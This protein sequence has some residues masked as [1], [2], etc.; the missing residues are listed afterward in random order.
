M[1]CSLRSRGQQHERRIAR[2]RLPPVAWRVE[3]RLSSGNLRRFALQFLLYL[4]FV[5]ALQYHTGIYQSEL[6]HQPDESAHVVTSLMIH[7]YAKTGIGTSPLRFAEN[8]Y[9]HYPKVAF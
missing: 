1:Y 7:D 4:P 3:T 8:Y 5:L 6:S 9:I 2:K